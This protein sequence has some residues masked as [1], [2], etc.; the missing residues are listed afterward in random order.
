MCLSIN[1]AAANLYVLLH[2]ACPAGFWIIVKLLS[3]G[4]VGG[5]ARIER[6]HVCAGLGSR[7][8]LGAP[9]DGGGRLLFLAVLQHYIGL[10]QKRDDRGDEERSGAVPFFFFTYW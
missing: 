5:G 4:V 3:H 9:S 8:V 1:K 7:H 6:A 2:G 10:K